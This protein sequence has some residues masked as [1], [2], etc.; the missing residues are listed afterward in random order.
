MCSFIVKFQ[1]QRAL[2][3]FTLQTDLFL[4]PVL[5]VAHATLILTKWNSTCKWAMY[6]YHIMYELAV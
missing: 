1:F 3:S 6:M 5:K 2:I 4:R